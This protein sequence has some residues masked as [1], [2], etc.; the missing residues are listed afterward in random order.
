MKKCVVI[1]NPKSGK[2]KKKQFTQTIIPLLEKYGYDTEV[3]YTQYKG[4]AI[5]LMQVIGSVDLVI[6]AGGD[7]TLNEVVTGN[8][9][10]K[11]KLL[12]APF[13]VGTG[14][15]VSK[16]Y[17]LTKDASKNLESLLKGTPK[18]LDIC[19]INQKPFVYVA[20]FGPFVDI[21][22]QTPRKLKEKYGS[23]GYII[24]ALKKLNRPIVPY[25]IRY[26]VNGKWERGEFTFI[27][28]TNS[29]RVAGISHIY[30]DVLLDDNQF[31]VLFCKAK[32]PKELIQSI[33]HF[34]NNDE[35]REKNII[36]FKTNHLEI[37]FDK[38]IKDSWCIDGEEYREKNNK[39][40][41]QVKKEMK[42]LVP[43]KKI[44]KLFHDE[45]F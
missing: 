8:F 21:A 3:L 28:I 18:K 9:L 27:F 4:H 30:N 6:A 34:M 24:Y 17:G 33:F 16:M 44:K 7:G 1:Y 22:Y 32:K 37:V 2:R 25:S 5:L 42:I 39:F 20:C 45:S 11:K 29:T 13:P 12:I 43:Q 31:E 23:F 41:F 38:E 40:L 26:R 15:D 36:S 10:R 35:K 19:F 14:N